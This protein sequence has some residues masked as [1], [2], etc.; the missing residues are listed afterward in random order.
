LRKKKPKEDEI[1]E[2]TE[3]ETKWVTPG[4]QKGSGRRDGL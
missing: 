1:E 3:M 4:E 2:K